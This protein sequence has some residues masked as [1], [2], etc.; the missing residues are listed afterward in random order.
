[1]ELVAECADLTIMNHVVF[2]TV[3]DERDRAV[4][5]SV[6]KVISELLWFCIYFTQ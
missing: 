1:M 4:F 6:S 3:M 2:S 5:S